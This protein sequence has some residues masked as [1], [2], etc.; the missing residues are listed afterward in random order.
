MDKKGIELEYLCYVDDAIYNHNYKKVSRWIFVKKH[1]A[2]F[3]IRKELFVILLQKEKDPS[4][5]KERVVMTV[6]WL[7]E[8][9]KAEIE[10]IITNNQSDSE[11]ALADIEKLLGDLNIEKLGKEV[12][13]H[14]IGLVNTQSDILNM[15][16]YGVVVQ[17]DDA[18][19]IKQLIDENY[20]K[21]S[22]TEKGA[23]QEA[24]ADNLFNGMMDLVCN[25]L[26]SRG[27]DRSKDDFY[28]LDVNEFRGIFDNSDYTKAE[29]T[30]FRKRLA[31]KDGSWT[32]IDTEI[33]YIKSNAGK[34]DYVIRHVNSDVKVDKTDKT[35][36]T[37]KTDKNEQSAT[38]VPKRFIVFYKEAIDPKI[39]EYIENNP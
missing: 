14:K 22:Y 21:I 13:V 8:V 10:D 36:K 24:I 29:L 38:K 39:D 5:N 9:T 4:T 17:R 15:R 3:S 30:G 32:P 28:I 37:A 23:Y 33:K 34:A 12:R 1:K 26:N 35:A 31:G 19:K 20:Y 6:K 16:D 27:K 2:I 18:F 7:D 11:K 25:H